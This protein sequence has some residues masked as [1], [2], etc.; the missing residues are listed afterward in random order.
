MIYPITLYGAGVL[1]KG[2]QEITAD[3]PD[4]KDFIANMFETMYKADGVGLAAPQV[5][6]SIRLFVIDGSSFEEDDVTMKDFKK[7]F[8]NP[9]IIERAG[10]QTTFNEGCLSIPDIREDVKRESEIRIQYYD[11]NFKYHDEHYAGLKARIIQHEYDHLDGV[12]FVDRISP[13]RKRMIRNKLTAI[14]RG[15]VYPPYATKMPRR[16]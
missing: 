13:I 7:V 11:E 1:R 15:K 2:T 12:L 10:K 6:S 4:L 14:A 3:Y 8:I 9:K 5:D 16:R